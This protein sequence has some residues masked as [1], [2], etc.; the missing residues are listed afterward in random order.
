LLI[1]TT[2]VPDKLPPVRPSPSPLH[3]T[4][5][6]LALLVVAMNVVAVASV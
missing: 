5:K 4:Q 6:A 3:T 2:P 1:P